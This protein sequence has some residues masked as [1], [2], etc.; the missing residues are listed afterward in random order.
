MSALVVTVEIDAVGETRGAATVLERVSGAT[1]SRKS[2]AALLRSIA[3]DLDPKPSQA[4]RDAAA[5]IRGGLG[6]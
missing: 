2:T 5:S 4:V 1:L 3:D 6:T